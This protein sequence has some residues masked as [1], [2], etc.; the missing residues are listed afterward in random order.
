MNEYLI[1]IIIL[2]LIFYNSISIPLTHLP[3]FLRLTIM[4][5]MLNIHMT[6]QYLSKSQLMYILVYAKDLQ[7]IIIQ[8]TTFCDPVFNYDP[9]CPFYANL[10]FVFC[11][12]NI[13]TVTVLIN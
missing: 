4:L 9:Q 6:L 1:L 12:P 3:L 2:N 7:K 8:K 5:W 10:A 13:L 11:M